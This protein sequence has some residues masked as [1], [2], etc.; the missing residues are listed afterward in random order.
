MMAQD[1]KITPRTGE[2]A[3]SGAQI[4]FRGSGTITTGPSAVT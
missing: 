2:T 3:G 1:I 4:L